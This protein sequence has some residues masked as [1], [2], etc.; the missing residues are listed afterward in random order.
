M[1]LSNKLFSQR[2]GGQVYKKF[3]LPK[4]QTFSISYA[5]N[6]DNRIFSS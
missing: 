2:E 1:D 3:P 5:K 4:T 6:I